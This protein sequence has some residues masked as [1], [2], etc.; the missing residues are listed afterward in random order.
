MVDI[1]VMMAASGYHPMISKSIRL[2]LRELGHDDELI[3][4]QDGASDLLSRTISGFTDTRL[5]WIYR[6]KNL[7][8]GE[9]RK[10]LLEAARGKF[11]AVMDSDDFALSGRFRKPAKILNQNRTDYVFSNAK[12]RHSRGISLWSTPAQA[13]SQGIAQA[14]VFKNVLVHSSLTAKTAS[15]KSIGYQG[16]YAEDYSHYV[17]AILEGFRLTMI[18]DHLVTYNV[19][20]E[21]ATAKKNSRSSALVRRA[22]SHVQREFWKNPTHSYFDGPEDAWGSL[23]KNNPLL[24]AK[25]SGF[26]R[27]YSTSFLPAPIFE[28]NE[29]IDRR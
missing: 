12:I 3:I 8:V 23:R 1:S 27:I 13:T 6:E 20:A 14:L 21:Q 2:T 9:T 19:H 28:R 16:D 26:K 25:I 22:L 4:L 29:G 11:S 24:A 5:R 7:G 10:E 15:L 18:R 17:M